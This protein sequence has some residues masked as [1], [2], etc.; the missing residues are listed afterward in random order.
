V[1]LCAI[2]QRMTAPTLAIHVNATGNG[3]EALNAQ[4]AALRANAAGLSAASV[5]SPLAQLQ[6]SMARDI[7]AIRL[8]LVAAKK[9]IDR[10]LQDMAD[11]GTR[12][13]GGG[14]Y[15]KSKIVTDAETDNEKLRTA[16]QERA[17]IQ[18]EAKA[19]DAVRFKD[20]SFNT[21][22]PKS[23]FD[24]GRKAAAFIS[25]GG[26]DEAATK[27]FGAAAVQ[28]SA[29]LGKL[30]QAALVAG[31][32]V[33]G[34]TVDMNDAHGAA[35]G[36]A[37]GLGQTLPMFAAIGPYI[38]AAGVAGA[39]TKSL[40]AGAKFAESLY[41]IGELA[42]TSAKDV[43]A[44]SAQALALGRSSQYGPLE[45]AKGMEI[46][47][48]AGLKASEVMSAIR[49]TLD[50]ASA[51][52]VST[53]KAAETLVAV[54][55]AYGY[56]AQNYSLVGDVIAKT[57][58]DSMASVD[59]MGESFKS[60]SVLA[61]QYGV[62][63]QDTATN[64]GFLAQIG[65]KGSSAGTSVRNMYTEL[66]KGSG[67]VADT[68]KGL[69]VEALDAEGKMKPLLDIMEKLSLS[70]VNKTG[71]AQKSIFQTISN[72]RGGKD[73]AAVQAAVTAQVN[74]NNDANVRSG[75]K[76]I[77]EQV[78]ALEKQG[79]TLAAN[80]LRVEA[81][82]KAYSS[83]REELAKAASETGGFT[84]FAAVEKSLTPLSQYKALVASLETTFVQ[85]FTGS[86]AAVDGTREAA[87]GAANALF[88]LGQTLKTIADS[89][90]FRNTVNASVLALSRLANATLDW[91]AVL[92]DR[93]PIAG[94]I[95][96]FGF[97]LEG[98]DNVEKHFTG[99]AT[100][101]RWAAEES[102]KANLAKNKI[103]LESFDK[104]IERLE[105]EAVLRAEG[106]SR[107]E[108]ATK[109]SGELAIERINISTQEQIALEKKTAARYRDIAAMAA[110]AIEN[111]KPALALIPGVGFGAGYAAD[112]AKDKLR[113]VADAEE[114]KSKA[115]IAALEK[116][117]GT[118]VATFK[119]RIE[120]IK[121]LT[122]KA[123]ADAE[124]QAAKNK[125]N[126][127]GSDSSVPAK[128]A[129]ETQTS[130]AAGTIEVEELNRINAFYKAKEDALKLSLNSEAKL[131]KAKYDA[132]A[133]SE[134][135]YLA[136]L[137]RIDEEQGRK[138]IELAKQRFNESELAIATARVVAQQKYGAGSQQMADVLTKETSLRQANQLQL[139]KEAAAVQRLIK[140][141][142]DLAYWESA[143]VINKA[144]SSSKE[145]LEKERIELEKINNLL[146]ARQ[147]LAGGNPA[148]LAAFEARNASLAKHETHLLALKKAYE[149]AAKTASDFDS[150][151][152]PRT[153]AELGTGFAYS[154][155]RDAA[156]FNYDTARSA[157]GADAD[158]AGRQALEKTY[159]DSA[160]AL[161]GSMVD[162]IVTGMTEGSVKGSEAAR[163]L[164]EDAFLK[165]PLK[166]FLEGFSE[167]GL[168]RGIS[169]LGGS[170]LGDVFGIGRGKKSNSGGFKD[171]NANVTSVEDYLRTF[172]D[173]L[174]KSLETSST[175]L[176]SLF[177][178]FGGG[179]SETFSKA[180]SALSELFS[181]NSSSGE[182]GGGGGWVSLIASLFAN[183][184][185]NAFGGSGAVTPFANGASFL[186]NSILTS[187][188]LFKFAKG[189]GVAGEA[190]PE[191]VMPLAR[192]GQGR[193][194]VRSGGA[195]NG[196]FQLNYAPV[197]HVD[198]RTD[199]ADVHQLV[200]SSHRKNR[201]ALLSYL[202]EKG[203][204]G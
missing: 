127:F 56:A 29:N 76:D 39:F 176:Q 109:I 31:S 64:L 141:R 74:K 135:N 7:T 122:A 61:Q 30:E 65:I 203:V 163:K 151:V 91:W 202:T 166:M 1:R 138:T 32:R 34:F 35:R 199:Q 120:S 94:A 75:A 20:A 80:A 86:A 48:L 36:L 108:A 186:T 129:K 187:P 96:G 5:Q 116:D 59:A 188:T 142:E 90:R 43:A 168:D 194:G 125:R 114:A 192:D 88:N 204:I 137:L 81:V 47:S 118:S 8:G 201:E 57:A 102:I 164:I 169:A 197:T 11:S 146:Q 12:L 38:V 149:D 62:S 128:A 115:R 132:G 46:L 73:L 55:T 150:Q 184:N 154:R 2:I 165:K 134:G 107:E 113:A 200:E 195:S 54:S 100:T 190:G 77:Y 153:A 85:A 42:Q 72:E 50:F 22:T 63:L 25:S 13:R 92:T 97:L 106:L 87:A 95:K 79:Q 157:L 145:Y 110:T 112:Y 67:K 21:A 101:E 66:A 89:D 15:S 78:A 191:A 49:P 119:S 111:A 70:L 182:G 6:R 144:N 121:T 98:L 37:R 159:L 148:E 162:A 27:A 16:A 193:L 18:A 19:A 26:S 124:A 130:T 136:D 83:L 10:V 93:G 103:S 51:G 179:I 45:V 71:A 126:L 52:G 33:K 170:A 105:R 131:L 53:E 177:E 17:R 23:Q 178:S 155:Q 133:T 152:G 104:Q 68:L 174:G 181:S 123:N 3:L 41:T 198:S 189:L 117:A 60:A 185:G 183:A 173:G 139:D 147:D 28:A 171:Y 172:D 175:G 158:A 161:K 58:A 143:K 69:G 167:G 84:F 196:G 9:D 82:T 40:I 156:K 4:L 44:L 24:T 140:E 99:V 14:S 180:A 160:K